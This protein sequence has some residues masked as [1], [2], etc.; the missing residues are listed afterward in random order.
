MVLRKVRSG[1]VRLGQ[2]RS[3]QVRVDGPNVSRGSACL[4]C[5]RTLTLTVRVA[6]RVLILILSRITLVVSGARRKPWRTMDCALRYDER[7]CAHRSPVVG[8][9]LC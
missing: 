5:R 6:V 2:V 3:G 4:K 8:R 7:V 9:F 1:Q